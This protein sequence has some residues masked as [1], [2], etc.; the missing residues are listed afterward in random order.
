MATYIPP[1]QRNSPPSTSSLP[2]I[3]PSTLPPLKILCF[4]DSLTEGFSM[5]G[6]RMTPYSDSLYATLKRKWPQREVE[7]H[8]DGVSGDLVTVPRG[9]F[10]KRMKKRCLCLFVLV[11]W[12]LF[13]RVGR[14]LSRGCQ[15]TLNRKFF[16]PSHSYISPK[17]FYFVL[18]S[19]PSPIPYPSPTLHFP[20]S[21]TPIYYTFSSTLPSTNL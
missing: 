15:V 21:S 12:A 8:T 11:F 19:F 13:W 3:S 14:W 17:P 4:G 16:L 20:L 1:N 18:P 7:V 2:S 10:G 6:L 9:E 5:M